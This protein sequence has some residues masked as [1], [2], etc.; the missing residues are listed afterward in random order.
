MELSE[1]LKTALPTAEDMLECMVHEC[2]SIIRKG[3]ANMYTVLVFVE[4]GRGMKSLIYSCFCDNRNVRN[5][6]SLI[7]NYINGEIVLF[8]LP[9]NILYLLIQVAAYSTLFMLTAACLYIV[10]LFLNY[11]KENQHSSKISDV[12]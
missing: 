11:A 5:C 9:Q 7:Y 12:Q 8:F 6:L 2:P 4:T 10:F 1:D 3:K